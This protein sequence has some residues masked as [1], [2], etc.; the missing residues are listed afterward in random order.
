MSNDICRSL[1]EDI[2]EAVIH[3]PLSLDTKQTIKP[4]FQ[5]K[6]P[7]DSTSLPS[8]SKL[9]KL[10]SNSKN[11]ENHQKQLDA[12]SSSLN[13]ITKE[14]DH[15]L[16]VAEGARQDKERLALENNR[17][18]LDCGDLEDT[19]EE[20]GRVCTLLASELVQIIWTLSGSSLGAVETLEQVQVLNICRITNQALV[21]YRDRSS[22]EELPLVTGLLGC[23]INLSSSPN[24]ISVF[25]QTEEGRGLV[26]EV[27][28]LICLPNPDLKLL[29]LSMMV[30]TNIVGCEL[31]F[32]HR[33]ADM[34]SLDSLRRLEVAVNKWRLAEK[35][36]GQLKEV[37][38][39]LGK[40]LVRKE[41]EGG[42]DN[43][44]L[45]PEL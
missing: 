3:P 1:L 45:Q 2:I 37:A 8:N 25:V 28:N 10:S 21:Q 40:I 11:N 34:L 18:S 44:G 14:R 35:V 27:C 39:R 38:D 36:R 22:H 32:C 17:L 42:K 15:W 9:T 4:R 23:L 30:V 20:Q 41:R 33:E 7:T 13:F 31:G 16:Q 26:T 5:S 19:V 43:E 24:F 12:L 6:R 29:E